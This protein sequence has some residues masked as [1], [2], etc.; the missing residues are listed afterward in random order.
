MLK[1]IF[2]LS[3]FC[4]FSLQGFSQLRE[5]TR[6]KQAF[7]DELT[8]LLEDADKKEG[9]ELMEENFGPFWLNSD[10]YN[11]AQKEKI[12]DVAD[13]M[14]KKRLR[15]FPFYKSFVIAL[16]SFPGSAQEG[17]GLASQVAA[18]VAVAEGDDGDDFVGRAW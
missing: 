2:F 3:L 14:L 11:D 4:I 12:Y 8:E 18:G 1:R 13:L 6:E 10:I 5:F 9:K 7:Y 15:P 16:L 17:E